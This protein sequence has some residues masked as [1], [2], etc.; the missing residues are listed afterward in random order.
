MVFSGLRLS[1]MVRNCRMMVF[2]ILAQTLGVRLVRDQSVTSCPM[3][4]DNRYKL[5][6]LAKTCH[7]LVGDWSPMG[8]DL[9]AIVGNSPTISADLLPTDCGPPV[10]RPVLH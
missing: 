5:D 10:V 8:G 4:G 6:G 2:S 7:P 3:V 1:F 9:R